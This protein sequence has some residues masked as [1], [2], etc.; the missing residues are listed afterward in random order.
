MFLKDVYMDGFKCYSDKT[1]IK[2]LDSSFTAIT[3]LNGSGKSNIID[4]IIFTLDLSTSRL[5]RVSSLKE[6]INVN[7]KDCSVTLVFDNSEKHKSPAGYE[8]CDCI[9]ITRSLD[10]EG[11]SKYR[12]NGHPSTKASIENL[13]KCIGITNDFIV[14]Q[15][16][17]TKIVNMKSSE[18]KSMIEETAGTRSYTAEREKSLELLNRKELKLKE[19]R[20][21][22]KRTISPF[23][24][25]LKREKRA[26][27]ENRE[28]EMRRSE[29]KDELERLEELVAG[30]ELYER[31]DEVKR[32]G[33]QYLVEK[34]EL[35]ELEARMKETM[36]QR[37]GPS[38]ASE[39]AAERG[40][41][42]ELN[43]ALRVVEESI[44]M[45]GEPSRDA[46]DSSGKDSLEAEVEELK[47]RERLLSRE[48][49][50]SGPEKLSELE[51]LKLQ[52]SR[53]RVELE[54]L[55][56]DNIT[57][58]EAD[59]AFLGEC[60]ERSS[61][62]RMLEEET[63]AL[64]NKLIYTITDGVYGTVDENF[65]FVDEKYKEAV[66]TALGGRAKFVICRDE[67]VASGMI[68]TADRKISCIPLNK[69]AYSEPG[70]VPFTC[71]NALEAVRF[72]KELERAFKHIFSGFYLFEDKAKAAACCFECKVV[73]ITLDG[74]V[75][76]PRGTLTGGKSVF[77]HVVT[78][79]ADVQRKEAEIAALRGAQPPAERLRAL[80]AGCQAHEEAGR[81]ERELS[82]L[83]GR[84]GML[85][86]L[87]EQTVNVKDELQRVRSRIVEAVKESKVRK[88]RREDVA[89][90]RL[91]REEAE[92]RREEGDRERK[93]TVE[94][95]ERLEREERMSEVEENA[96]R[97]S[98]RL[99]DGQGERVKT[100]VRS[101]V[102]LGTR[103]S[104]VAEEIRAIANSGSSS[105]RISKE[106]NIRD[107]NI[108]GGN[109]NENIKGGNTSDITTDITTDTTIRLTNCLVEEF[110]VPRETV[111]LQQAPLGDRSAVE[112]RI[113]F[114]KE[115]IGRKAVVSM[116]PSCFELLEKNTAAVQDLEEKIR[117]LESDRVEIVRSIERLDF[118]G[119][120]ENSRAFGHIN[121][122]LGVFLS[123]F[124]KNAD[125]CI[126]KD[127]EIRV[128]IGTWKN[129]LG[130]LSGGQKSLVAL[131]L[132]FSM[133]AFKPAP[134]YIFDEI[135]SALDLNY[136][137][138]IGEIIQKEFKGAQFI[139]VS[140]KNNM[141]ENAN[142]VFK[143]FIQDQ[144]SKVCQLK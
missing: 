47:E 83:G 7:R 138:F 120:E 121:R 67:E 113:Q 75:Y 117:K 132:I 21:H 14:M 6:L 85:E 100:L 41:L 57:V 72:K 86:G 64:R 2:G 12:L 40:R 125:A 133:L 78:R 77:R 73:C 53:K 66:L 20:E 8:S 49:L 52:Q 76:D 74:T 35:R 68:Q 108:K 59:L 126:S 48:L 104:R 143:V 13:C 123:Y 18:L 93:E 30:A 107:E 39:L 124:L 116:D 42:E 19:A 114:L 137:Q 90:E 110:K 69:I 134:F 128:K 135:D 29:Y 50:T 91:E 136:T 109:R 25:E 38:R 81:L 122:T 26:Y 99:M 56:A 94:R 140:L 70:R 102:K 17:I 71:V 106:V 87:V 111:E 82:G 101:T 4:A 61:K 33:M 92:R 15:G 80:K 51:G 95:I 10:I 105:D 103:M 118:M 43:E 112:E 3:G 34:D 88:Q 60:E 127:F 79:M 23:F 44:R 5:M 119:V 96:R 32:M 144:R 22:L 62:I 131:C 54:M 9:E 27:E 55:K 97:A 98:M 142:R 37:A 65:E 63:S 24:E 129:G 28:L 89:R 58:S 46:G 115:R 1:V 141:F 45:M 16:Q 84:I 130:E 11:K 36:S 139:I 31:V